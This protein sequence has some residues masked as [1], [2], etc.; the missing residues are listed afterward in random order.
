MVQDSALFFRYFRMSPTK[1]EELLKK[2]APRIEKS[3]EKKPI[4]PSER[5]SIALKYLF[6]NNCSKLSC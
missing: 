1:F 2:V 6:T 5:L 4:C 3:A